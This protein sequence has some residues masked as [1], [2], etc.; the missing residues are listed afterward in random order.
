MLIDFGTA[1]EYC[2]E[3][4]SIDTTYLGTRGYAAP[5]QYGGMGQTD[6]RTDIY[7]LGVTLYSMLTGYSPEKTAL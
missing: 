5:E 4:N 2:Y 7:C 3:K 6:E 1:R